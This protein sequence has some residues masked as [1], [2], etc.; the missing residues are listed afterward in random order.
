MQLYKYNVVMH[1][2]VFD[3]GG[4]VVHAHAYAYSYAY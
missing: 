1:N 3:R 2:Q 4:S